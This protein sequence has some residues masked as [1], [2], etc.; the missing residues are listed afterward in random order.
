MKDFFRNL[1]CWILMAFVLMVIK[2][3]KWIEEKLYL[4]RY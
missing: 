1:V 4:M 2:I 3:G